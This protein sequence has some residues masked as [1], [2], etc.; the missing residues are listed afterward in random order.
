M[1]RFEC[2][3]ARAREDYTVLLDAQ[4]KTE[5]YRAEG[6]EDFIIRVELTGEKRSL[7]WCNTYQNA[8]LFRQPWQ[9]LARENVESSK[10]G[11]PFRHPFHVS[12]EMADAGSTK[13]ANS[14]VEITSHHVFVVFV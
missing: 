2:L 3:S 1:E 4:H 12:I 5:V 7:Q 13:I 11:D 14:G 6:W 8:Q 9:G 10:C